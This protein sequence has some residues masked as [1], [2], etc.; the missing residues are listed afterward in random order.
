ML[1]RVWYD[2]CFIR[3]FPHDTWQKG[4]QT[5]YLLVCNWAFPHVL[6]TVTSCEIAMLIWRGI[7]KQADRAGPLENLLLC[8]E[9]WSCA[10]TTVDFLVLSE[11]AHPTRNIF[12][13]KFMFSAHDGESQTMYKYEFGERKRQR[14]RESVCVPHVV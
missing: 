14:E 6:F 13:L 1:Y 2:A 7:L 10:A 4:T 11:C 8:S 5:V 9:A 3:Y 12:K